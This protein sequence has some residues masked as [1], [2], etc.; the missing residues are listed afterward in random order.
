VAPLLLLIKGFGS[1]VAVG[2]EIT[3]WISEEF[4]RYLDAPVMRLG[5]MDSAIPFSLRLEKEFCR[6]RRLA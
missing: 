2:A 5:S 1:K 6:S 4:F 3:A